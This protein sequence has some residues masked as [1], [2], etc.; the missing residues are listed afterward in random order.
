M[1]KMLIQGIDVDIDK[2]DHDDRY[3]APIGCLTEDQESIVMTIGDAKKNM[4]YYRTHWYSSYGQVAHVPIRW[5]ISVA[6]AALG[7]IG[8]KSTSEAK[9]SASRK[10]GKMGGRPK[11]D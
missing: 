4:L 3:E 2:L 8:G 11:N 5:T 6:A 10:N 1:K 9:R 7:R